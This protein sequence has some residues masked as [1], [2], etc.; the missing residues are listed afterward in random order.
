MDVKEQQPKT[1]HTSTTTVQLPPAP[2]TL[3]TLRM[4]ASGLGVIRV[5]KK[6]ICQDQKTLK[7]LTR[8]R[9]KRKLLTEVMVRWSWDTRLPDVRAQKQRDLLDTISPSPDILELS[10]RSSFSVH[11]AHI[12]FKI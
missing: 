9:D 8:W 4:R 7:Y 3:R 11:K 6:R 10:L 12:M 5:I 1:E 2:L